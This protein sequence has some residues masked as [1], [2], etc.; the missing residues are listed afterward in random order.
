[1]NL[2]RVK[3][4]LLGLLADPKREWS[5]VAAEPPDIVW[6]YRH[7]I[8]FVAAIPA[9]ALLVGFAL[10]GAPIVGLSVALRT[11][12]VALLS[13]LMVALVVERLAPRFRSSGSTAQVFKLAA[14]SFAPAWIA[15]ALYLIPSLG[16]LA[17]VVGILYGV[18]LYA[19]G[20]PRLMQT[21]REQIVP[22]MVVSAL[23]VLVVTTVL[24]VL[25]SSS[26]FA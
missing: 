6:V 21:P 8:A 5:A 15:G 4:R 9:A 17:T 3:Q 7:Y 23:V 20:L 24:R 11:Y 10:A 19:L 13:P 1:L 2:G 18:Y 14:F 22:F 25:L 16:A 26:R 12:L